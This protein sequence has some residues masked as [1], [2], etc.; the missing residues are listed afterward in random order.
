MTERS[1][2]AFGALARLIV[3]RPRVVV[4]LTVSLILAGA[5]LFLRFDSNLLGVGYQVPGSESEQASK[6]IEEQTGFTETD[7]LVVASDSLTFDDN[8]FQRSFD[9]AVD[10]IREENDELRVV[11]P[12]EPGGGAISEDRH[13]ATATVY[14]TG[15]V[16]D[17]QK[18]AHHLQDVIDDVVDDP[19]RAGLTGN[20]PVLADLVHTEEI[21]V[22]K[23]EL[24]G[25]PIALL[26]LLLAFGS[27]VA[28]L[29]PLM[30]AYGGLIAAI[31]VVA[32]LM[33]LLDFNSFAETFM[34]MFGLALGIDYSLLFVRRF[35]EERRRGGTD[36][37]V[38]E[39]TLRTAG[40]TVLFSGTIFAAALIPVLPSGL[41]FF[42]DTMLAVI[43]V[44]VIELLLLVTLLPVVL[45]KLGDRLDKGRLPG[46]LGA[47]RLN[48]T[49]PLWSRWAR[50]VMRRPLAFL[51][52]GVFLLG[53]AATPVLDVETGIDL[54]VR[55]LSG[56]ESVE[57][58]TD[59]QEHFPNAAIAPI[60]VL[61]RGDQQAIQSAQAVLDRAGLTGIATTEIGPGAVVIT[62]QSAATV[63]SLESFE[64]IKQLRANLADAVPTGEVQV[65][66][67]IAETVDYADKTATWQPWIIGGALVLS[68]LLLLMIFRSP[69]LAAKAI[70]MNLLSIGAAIGLTVLLFQDGHAEGLLDFE[71]PGYLQHWMPLTL[72]IMLFGLS[73]DYEV[74]MVSRIREEYARLGNTQDAIA[75][76]LERTGSVITYAAAIMMV[77]F[78][79]FCLSTVPEMKQLGIG[80]ALA[81]L[82]DATI[83][84]M[85]LVPAFMRLAGDWNWWM[86]RWLDRIL[87]TIHHDT[88]AAKTPV[89]QD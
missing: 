72:F 27:V 39:R 62:G 66:G 89:P 32:L 53:A 73:M 52:G 14:L 28:A 16:A 20:S 46:R 79:A 30:M 21:D 54:N 29:L 57:P 82:I 7:L 4:L 63:D 38:V 59:L 34:V 86:P 76:G 45:L 74:F 65:T 49:S 80:L 35:R 50:V 87:P 17:R 2:G 60:E 41:P 3:E 64:E 42:Y 26:L 56:K 22:A 33:F 78:G 67:V 9:A 5:A 85:V 58:I 24:V 10:A 36:R 19:L 77:I 13:V 1:E 44:V 75:V 71:S 43:V 8:E 47:G 11:P 12:G 51:A 25:L 55:A 18:L 68:F 37:E 83:V 6:F 40:R 15:D 88:P 81:V 23:A 31:G 84:R 69:L 70:V 48:E 61:V